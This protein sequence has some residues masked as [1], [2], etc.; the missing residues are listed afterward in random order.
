MYLV[1]VSQYAVRFSVMRLPIEYGFIINR[2]CLTRVPTGSNYLNMLLFCSVSTL[3]TITFTFSY[4]N[5]II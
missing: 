1:S 3:T 2:G 5:V 4:Y